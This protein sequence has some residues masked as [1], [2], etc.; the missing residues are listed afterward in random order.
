MRTSRE[1][2]LIGAIFPTNCTLHAHARPQQAFPASH[3][4]PHPRSPPL[5]L[6]LGRVDWR[7][8]ANKRYTGGE[9][10]W[11]PAGEG[12]D[13]YPYAEEDYGYPSAPPP[14]PPP[15]GGGQRDWDGDA[16]VPA[17][18]RIGS[19]KSKARRRGKRRGR[20]GGGGSGDG[21]SRTG[22]DGFDE[23]SL[24]VKGTGGHGPLGVSS[25]ERWSSGPRCWRRGILRYDS[26]AVHAC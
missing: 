15:A 25:I 13:Q 23:V 8:S 6:S 10:Q 18:G 14:P 3:P 21:G 17:G 9:D 7:K 22:D 16:G 20:S 26:V 11:A 2:S 5:P 19:S 12:G 24:G 1:N 4:N